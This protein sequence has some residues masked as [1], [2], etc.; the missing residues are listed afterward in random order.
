MLNVDDFYV[1]NAVVSDSTVCD[2]NNACDVNDNFE[3]IFEDIH[4]F[5]S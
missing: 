3:V 1:A 4:G 5:R 2:V